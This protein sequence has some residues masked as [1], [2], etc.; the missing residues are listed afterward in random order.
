MTYLPFPLI[1]DQSK[2]V[3]NKFG[4][5]A[6]KKFMGKELLQKLKRTTFCDR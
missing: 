5:W 2:E 1:S 6:F 4:V 3:L